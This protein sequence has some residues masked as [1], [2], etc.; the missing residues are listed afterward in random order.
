MHGNE[1]RRTT[2]SEP[3]GARAMMMGFA[4]ADQIEQALARQSRLAIAGEKKLL[5]MLLVE[6]NVISTTQLLA[7]L[8]TYES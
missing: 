3:F 5:G 4:N 2:R 6:M 8:K 1:T 7:V